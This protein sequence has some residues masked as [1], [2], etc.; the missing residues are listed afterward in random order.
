MEDILRLVKVK[1]YQYFFVK[2]DDYTSCNHYSC[3]TFLKNRQSTTACGLCTNELNTQCPVKIP[4]KSSNW[5]PKSN[6]YF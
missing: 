2:C 4:D 1:K 6:T 3:I 5:G